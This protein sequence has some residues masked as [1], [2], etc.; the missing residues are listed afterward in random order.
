LGTEDH[1]QR[2]IAAL[3]K[4][5]QARPN[6][7]AQLLFDGRR[8]RR[9]SRVTK[10]STV[11]LLEPILAKYPGR[12]TLGLLTM[13]AA[14]KVSFLPSPL[15]EIAGVMHMKA[16]A[17]D[18]ELIISGANLSTGTNVGTRVAATAAVAAVVEVAAV[19]RYCCRV[20]D[21]WSLILASR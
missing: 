16:F 2:L 20:V 14:K 13:P 7:T 6:V 17:V 18:D 10:M 19:W 21:G 9:V 5:L 4:T 12:I 11:S 1:E 15:D 8:A 3:D